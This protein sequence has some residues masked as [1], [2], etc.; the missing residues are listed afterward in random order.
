MTK[1]PKLCDSKSCTQ[2][3]AC[4]E[5]CKQHAINFSLPDVC[6]DKQPVIDTTAC[7]GCGL[8]VRICPQ[9]KMHK[10]LKEL[11]Y[12]KEYYAGWSKNFRLKGSSG[13]IFGEL[14]SYVLRNNGYVCGASFD[15][16]GHLKHQIIN[17]I[18]LLKVLLG[19]KY[20]TSEVHCVF[21]KIKHLLKEGFVVL[22]VGTSCQVAGL[23]NYL[24]NDY[25]NLITIDLVCFGAPTQEVYQSFICKI[26]TRKKIIGYLFRRL[27]SNRPDFRVKLLDGTTKRLSN[28]Y[29]TYI[30]GFVRGLSMKKACYNCK[31]KNM[32]RVGDI[33]MG[34]YHTI[35]KE[36]PFLRKRISKGV[37]L[38][39]INTEKGNKFFNLV[40]DRFELFPK[41]KTLAS[42]TNISLRE[43]LK[44][45]ERR[46]YFCRLMCDKKVSLYDINKIF[47]FQGLKF[48]F[49]RFNSTFIKLLD[50]KKD[51]CQIFKSLK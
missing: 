17:D 43:Q 46:D 15:A 37:S 6:G 20:L 5:V 47:N 40:S 42:A 26:P 8:C 29:Y 35:S 4:I 24:L 22:F 39:I 38:I 1:I 44:E 49:I 11:I 2:C 7:V 32:D 9:L 27:D 31:Y 33:T 48:S 18:S 19:S 30:D 28:K 16:E 25:A 50:F 12:S 3:G 41:T 23:K 21:P 14:A 34:D 36:K 10:E 13:G 45:D 51:I